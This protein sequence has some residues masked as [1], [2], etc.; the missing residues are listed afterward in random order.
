MELLSGQGRA[1]QQVHTI[2]NEG[3]APLGLHVMLLTGYTTHEKIVLFLSNLRSSLF[4]STI[5]IAFLK[6]RQEKIQHFL[7]LGIKPKDYL[8]YIPSPR[9]KL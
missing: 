3:C 6:K 5:E 4:V 8:S 7:V 1:Q 2:D 9:V